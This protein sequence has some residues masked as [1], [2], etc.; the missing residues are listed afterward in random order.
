MFATGIVKANLNE[1]KDKMVIPRTA[2]L[3]TGKR[4]VV[5]VKQTKTDDPVFKIREIELGPMLGGSYVVMS[6]LNNGE[7]IVTQGAFSVDASAQLEG[8]PSMMNPSGGKKA[9]SM[10]GMVMPGDANSEYNKSMPG[11]TKS[12]DNKSMPGMN[13]SANSEGFTQ[14][15]ALTKAM[16][17]VSGSCDLCKERIEKAARSVAGVASADWSAE[18][19]QIH[20]QFD[21]TKT[22]T[23]AIQQAIS[24]VGH[25]TEKFKA[26]N[27]VYNKLPECC[28]YRK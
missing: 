18:K 2:V 16:F 6:G 10:P 24:K 21:S 15:E 25:D 27:E 19:K 1:Y 23:D 3:W 8:K 20:V 13:M 22:N 9:T 7:E 11:D 4:S 14:S 17:K 12:Q 26:T 5:Y 28:L